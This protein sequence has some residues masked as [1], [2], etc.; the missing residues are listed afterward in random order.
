LNYFVSRRHT[1][2]FDSHHL[3]R[4]RYSHYLSSS[5]PLLLLWLQFM[6]IY[7]TDLRISNRDPYNICWFEYYCKV[8]SRVFPCSLI[9]IRGVAAFHKRV[10]LLRTPAHDERETIWECGTNTAHFV[11]KLWVYRKIPNSIHSWKDR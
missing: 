11:E 7:L 1:L 8:T 2:R 5:T 6:D 9:F 3:P 4:K 10:M